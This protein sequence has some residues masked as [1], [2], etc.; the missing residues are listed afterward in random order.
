M[1]LRK[2]KCWT[3]TTLFLLPS[4]ILGC[5]P[6]WAAF[7]FFKITWLVHS[8]QVFSFKKK[9]YRALDFP[10]VPLGK[11]CFLFFFFPFLF[12]LKNFGRGAKG[13]IGITSKKQATCR[14]SPLTAPIRSEAPS[15]FSSWAKE[16]TAA[17]PWSIPAP[18]V[19]PSM[20][21]IR[22][23]KIFI[24]GSVLAYGNPDHFIS[25]WSVL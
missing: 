5:S 16:W 11:D 6:G 20:Q 2:F 8:D 25:I 19:S 9:P 17:N 7:V 24:T 14:K 12:F 13:K 18:I 1:V 4:A 3:A 23:K 21:P 15:P 10:C 22:L